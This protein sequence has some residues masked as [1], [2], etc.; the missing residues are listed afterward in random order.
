[1]GPSSRAM[2]NLADGPGA[3]RRGRPTS[4]RRRRSLLA[5]HGCG[6]RETIAGRGPHR[7]CDPDLLPALAVLRMPRGL[8]ARPTIARKVNRTNLC[9]FEPTLGMVDRSWFASSS[10]SDVPIDCK[11]TS[12]QASRPSAVDRPRCRGAGE[13]GHLPSTTPSRIDRR[14]VGP[15]WCAAGE[16]PR[17]YSRAGKNCAAHDS[18]S[19]RSGGWGRPS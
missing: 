19:G 2:T 12:G 14:A 17:R 15:A 18:S 4:A 9:V 6:S 11:Q 16:Q 10:K 5:G 13:G 1:M 7:R 3:S 8:S